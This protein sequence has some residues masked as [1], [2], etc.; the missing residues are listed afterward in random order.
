MFRNLITLFL[1]QLACFM[2]IENHFFYRKNNNWNNLCNNQYRNWL[3]DS[4]Y[5]SNRYQYRYVIL[6]IFDNRYGIIQTDPGRLFTDKQE[7]S[8]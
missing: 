2:K 7:Q 5:R 3:T 4:G 6:N 1:V 8:Y